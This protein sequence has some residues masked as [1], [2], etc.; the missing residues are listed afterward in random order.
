MRPRAFLNC[1]SLLA[2]ALFTAQSDALLS[3][4]DGGVVEGRRSAFLSTSGSFTLSSGG[5]QGGGNSEDI[6][7]HEDADV[8]ARRA[9]FLSTSGSFRGVTTPAATPRIRALD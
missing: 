2:V 3:D 4:E 7:E 5:V 1:A 6:E 8:E 9:A